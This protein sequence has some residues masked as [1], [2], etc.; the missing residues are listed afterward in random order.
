M[1][2]YLTSDLQGCVTYIDDVLVYSDTWEDHVDRVRAL[3]ERL[4]EASLVMNLSK[5]EFVQAKVQ[6]L[7]YVIGQGEV[8]PP[9]AKVKAICDIVRPE[10]RRDIRKFLGMVG[11]YRMFIVNFATVLAPLTDLLKKGTKFEWTEECQQAFNHLKTILCNAPV[12]QAPNFEKQFKLA[13]DA[14]QVGAGA[15]LIQEDDKN[16]D[17]P[18]CYFSKK[19]NSAQKNYSVIEK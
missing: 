16:V 7:G 13:C 18:V 14:S 8:A 19:F 4:S 17:H 5:C 10:C 3:L 2:N 1:M 6:Y 12:L 11:Y 15:V 9:D